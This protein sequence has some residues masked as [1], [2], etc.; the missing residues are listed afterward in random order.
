M[1]NATAEVDLRLTDFHPSSSL[2]L[3]S[4]K[5]ERSFFPAI[6]YHNHLDSTNPDKVLLVMDD[7]N[8]E[9][10]VNITMQVGQPALEMMDRFHFASPKR[11]SSIGWMDWS[12]VDAR[13]DF[14][15]VTIDRLSR[16]IEHGACGIKILER[17]WANPTR[18]QR[19]SPAY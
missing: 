5:I 12:G 3:P 15:Q 7:C 9:H 16:M 18:Q 1:V 13:K 6:D 17:L 2:N 4:H 19:R 14:A 10:I 11:F 8:V